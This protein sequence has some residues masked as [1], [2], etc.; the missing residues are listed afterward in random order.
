MARFKYTWRLI[1]FGKYKEVKTEIK[2]PREN[3]YY[4]VRYNHKWVILEWYDSYWINGNEF[5]NDYDFDKIHE[6]K[7]SEPFYS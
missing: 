7:L 4:W 1:G 2:E 3:G 5:L 6:E